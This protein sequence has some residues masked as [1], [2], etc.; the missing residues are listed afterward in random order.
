MDGTRRS[1]AFVAALHATRRLC[2]TLRPC[3]FRF[4]THQYGGLPELLEHIRRRFPGVIK[5]AVSKM[6]QS[7][8]SISEEFRAGAN[9]QWFHCA[10]CEEVKCG[11][12]QPQTV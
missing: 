7:G 1:T 6:P 10:Q 12:P 2:I 9:I 11:Q 3:R 4:D 8:F 5:P